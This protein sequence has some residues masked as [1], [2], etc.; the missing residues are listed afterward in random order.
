[1][2]SELEA[3]M[4][5]KITVKM[6]QAEMEAH[7]IELMKQVKVCVL[8]T[9][10]NDAPRATPT[11]YF[12]DG[13]NIYTSPDPGKKLINLRANPKI[14]IAIF[15]SLNVNWEFD[16]P[17]TWGIQY[18]GKAEILKDGDPEYDYGRSVLKFDPY[19]IDPKV[20]MSRTRYVLKVVPE[21][22]ELREYALIEKGYAYRQVWRG[23]NYTLDD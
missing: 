15:S 6:P 22:I 19:F 12:L 4:K 14:S 20:G 5:R 11:E 2:P 1:M 18:S 13:L 10:L 3:A 7:L 8:A 17:K 21:K 9:S 16:W 23:P